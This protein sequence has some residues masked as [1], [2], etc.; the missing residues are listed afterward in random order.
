MAWYNLSTSGYCWYKNDAADKSIYGALYNWYTV[1]TSKLC[2]TGWHEPSDAE[3]TALTTYLGGE[4]IAGG[5]LKETGASHWLSPNTTATNTTKFT[6]VPGGYRNYDG[7]FY[8]IGSDGLL[9]TSSEFNTNWAWR[10]LMI[11]GSS[12]VT[13]YGYF[14]NAGYSVRC[15]QNY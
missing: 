10:S 12:A 9:W 14:K 1:N 3:W 13:R 11:Y 6:A 4:S 8:S 2:P 5:K 7:A 15:L